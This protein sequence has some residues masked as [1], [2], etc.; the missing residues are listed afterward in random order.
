LCI[1]AFAKSKL[2][3]HK[4]DKIDSMIIAEYASKNDL[5]LYVPK[6]YDLQELQ[7]LYR[8]LQNL[9]EQYKQSQNYLENKD[10]LSSTICS[11]YKR[12]SQN[13]TKE[14][15]KIELEIDKPLVH[16][17]ELKQKADNIQTI[18][19]IGKLTAVAILA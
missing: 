4:T 3:R 11:S 16:N 14:I 13:I 1:S 17:H 5:S 6:N 12:L 7:N 19:G 8:C 18:P 10:H 2:S 15:N 9:K